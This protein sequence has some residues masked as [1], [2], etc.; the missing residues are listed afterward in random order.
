MAVSVAAASQVTAYLQDE[1]TS[2]KGLVAG[3]T[4]LVVLSLSLLFA[5]T[6]PAF[7]EP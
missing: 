6:C 5:G 7:V 4:Y 3:V 2:K 1:T